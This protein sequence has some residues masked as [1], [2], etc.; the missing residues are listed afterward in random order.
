MERNRAAIDEFATAAKVVKAGADVGIFTDAPAGIVFVVTVDGHKIRVPE[1]HV[2]AN[3]AALPGVPL[4][5][6]H[7]PANAFGGASDFAGEHPTPGRNEVCF[8]SGNKF[9]A[10]KAAPSLDPI[11]FLGQSGVIGN[12]FW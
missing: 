9:F 12:K 6:G 4:D 2:T 5:N 3:D 1:G 11:T 10:H 8:K 7:R